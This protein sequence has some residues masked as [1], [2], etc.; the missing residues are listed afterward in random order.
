MA[1]QF[2]NQTGVAS[3]DPPK[4]VRWLGSKIVP[5]RV[6]LKRLL[7]ARQKVERQ[8]IKAGKPHRVEYFHQV[9][10][11]YSH[12]AVQ[13]LKP[14]LEAYDI[15]INVQLV[16]GPSG[17][18]LPE[19]E[20]LPSY[21]R[22]DC[23]QVAPYY[24]L[25]FP[26]PCQVAGQEELALAS[27]I[28]AG[29]VGKDFAAVAIAVGSAIWRGG[30]ALQTLAEN[31]EPLAQ[32]ETDKL[33]KQGTERQLELKHYS[34]G[35]FFYGGEWYW[36]IDRLYHLE[37]RL[38]ELGIAKVGDGKLVVPRPAIED[39]PLRD[40]GSLTLE[41]YPSLRSPYT[42][43]S[44]DLSVALARKVGARLVLR[45]VLPMVM[46]GVSLTREKGF[47]ILMDTAREA[48]ELGVEGFGGMYDPI[49]EPVRRG[50]SLFPWAREKGREAELLS[51]FLRAAF[52]E[53]INTLSDRG[54]RQVVENAGLPWDEARTILGNR[55]WEAEMEQNRLAMYEWDSWG[56]PSY[57]LLGRSGETI[58]NFWGQ[59][60]LWVV[61]REI[62]RVLGEER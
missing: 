7:R 44:F 1:E 37:H 9:D 20:L 29:A 54:M 58:A 62:Q 59:D 16:A 52:F 22:H 17:K 23:E 5:R 14:L 2:E 33:V 27:R 60:R 15:E 34:G 45:P 11:P 46:R 57:R 56:V 30:G 18:N 21:S 61:A 3:S 42:A 6:S 38:I 19:P 39:G 51:A 12:L 25:D 50:F 24:G 47:Y 41:I 43:I 28:L 10:D 8:R 40:D 32:I 36:G 48:R 26:N 55:D 4:F 35:M 53:S 13:V 49:G 31:H